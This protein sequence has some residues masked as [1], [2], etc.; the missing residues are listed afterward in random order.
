MSWRRLLIPLAGVPLVAVLGYGLTRDARLVP[1]P[2]PGKPAPHFAL[3]TLD[4]D[5]LR[6]TDLAGHVVLVN[7][8]ASWCLACI[9]EHPLLVNASK[10]YYDEGL[11][12][13]GV[14]YQDTRENAARWMRERGG[15]WVN[16]LDRGSRTAIE[17]GILGVP[18]TFFISRSGRV[19]HKQ[20]GP[21]NAQVLAAWL[22]KL[23][24]ESPGPA[25]PAR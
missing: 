23:L 13:V 16:V 18:E 24:S 20:I 3:E 22:P 7:F 6:L 1:S 19:A 2:L 8:W 5:T 11:R 15:D 10:E 17:Y 12:V 21:I 14:V 9:D 4:G 25:A